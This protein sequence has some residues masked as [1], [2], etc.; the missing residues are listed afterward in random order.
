[1]WLCCYYR[2]SSRALEQCRSWISAA[3]RMCGATLVSQLPEGCTSLLT[4][5]LDTVSLG[6]R[7][8]KKPS[9]E[10]TQNLKKKNMAVSLSPLIYVLPREMFLTQ[11]FRGFYTFH[12]CCVNL[13]LATWWWLWR[14]CLSEETSGPPW[15]TSL[16]CWRLKAFST[17]ALTQAGWTGLSQ[18]RCRYAELLFE[19]IIMRKDMFDILTH[20]IMCW[21]HTTSKCWDNSKLL[22]LS[23]HHA[24]WIYAKM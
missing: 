2:V 11:L 22:Y 1:M 4:P 5:S 20:I 15:N 12:F 8:V 18:R 13:F 21:N 14:S 9:R 7:I 23:S 10:Y 24:V 16:S 6:E 19:K 17:T 3:I